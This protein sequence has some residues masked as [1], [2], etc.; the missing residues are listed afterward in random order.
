MAR[1]KV[2][3]KILVVTFCLS[4][5][6]TTTVAFAA[7]VLLSYNGTGIRDMDSAQTFELS[8]QTKITL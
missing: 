1:K 8:S 3:S 5:F 7:T 4:L 6:L 2:F